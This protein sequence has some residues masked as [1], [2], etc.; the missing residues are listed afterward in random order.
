MSTFDKLKF[1]WDDVGAVVGKIEKWR[2]RKCTTEKDYERSLY[3]YLHRELPDIQI[4]KQYAKGR[5]RAELVVADRVV[6]ELKHN[7][8]STAKYHRLIGQLT[9]YREWEGRVV[10][11]PTGKTEPNLRKQLN[12]YLEREGLTGDDGDRAKVTI[13]ER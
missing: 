3:D 9:E 7:L 11:L 4:T 10:L 2:P 8:D 12:E 5:I 6:I 13:Y 1:W